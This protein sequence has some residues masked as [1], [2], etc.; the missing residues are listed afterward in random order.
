LGGVC[1]EIDDDARLHGGFAALA[2]SSVPA[3]DGFRL[4]VIDP[5]SGPSA[6]TG[7]VGL[8]SWQFLAGEINAAGGLKV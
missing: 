6:T 5:L 1:N 2:A 4:A 8:K 7:E 3:E